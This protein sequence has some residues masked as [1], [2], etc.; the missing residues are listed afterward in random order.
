MTP[1]THDLIKQSRAWLNTSPAALSLLYNHDRMPEQLVEGSI[2]WIKTMVLIDDIR[3][4]W[5]EGV[6]SCTPRI[7]ELERLL[8]IEQKHLGPSP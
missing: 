4:V 2:Q 7:Q 1:E 3:N 5:Q 6:D 8:A